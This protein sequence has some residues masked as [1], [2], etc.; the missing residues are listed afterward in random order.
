MTEPRTPGLHL[1][2]ER[3]VMLAFAAS[4]VVAAVV[5]T[6]FVYVR[7]RHTALEDAFTEQEAFARTL[8]AVFDRELESA[9]RSLE[10]LARQDAV[11]RVP[12]PARIS[13]EFNGVPESLE[14]DRRRVFQDFQ[15]KHPE[16]SVIFL[17]LP[18]GDQYISH[19]FAVQRRLVK[20]NLFDRPYFQEVAETRR[21][22]ISDS[23]LGSDGERAVA[24]D[25]P[26]LD[27]LGGIVAHLGGVLHLPDLSRFL[28]P[29]RIGPY[30]AGF[31]VDR[32]GALIAHTR[33]EMLTPVGLSQFADH[34]LLA[35]QPIPP[36]G[37]PG[38]KVVHTILYVDPV[39]GMEYS[40]TVLPLSD[41]RCFG[42]MRLMAEINGTVIGHSVRTAA[43][44]ALLMLIVS[45]VGMLA[46]HQV[47]QRWDSA[48]RALRRAHDEMEDQVRQRNADLLASY[49]ALERQ[50]AERK[51]A[52]EELRA[53][54]ERL[55][56]LVAA[57]TAQW[58][59]ANAKLKEEVTERQRAEES[60]SRRE[61]HLRAVV[62][63]APVILFATDR[64]GIF[65]VSEG[66]GLAGL[67][68][69]P[70]QV[71]GIS[72]FDV[73]LDRPDIH[74][75]IRRA[76]GG[77]RLTVDVRAGAAMFETA[78]APLVAESGETVGMIGVATDVSE[79]LRAEQ[80]LRRSEASQAKA[81]QIAHLGSWEWDLRTNEMTWSDELYRILG[82]EPGEAPASYEGYLE[83][84]HPAHREQ[85]KQALSRAVEEGG[86]V[87]LEHS[88]IQR[89]E[90]ERTV[91]LRAEV[92]AGVRATPM[93]V[94]A[95]VHD[96]HDRKLAEQELKSVAHQLSH[97]TT[98][99]LELAYLASHDLQEPANSILALSERIGERAALDAE[100]RTNLEL[101]HRAAAR[102][103]TL[104]QAMLSLAR[105]TTQAQPLVAIDLGGI[106]TEV[107]DDL[108]ARMEAS[109]GEVVVGNLPLVRGDPVQV[110]QLLQNLIG[111]ALKF[112]RPEESPRVRV[113]LAEALGEP[114]APPGF[115]QIAVEDNGIGFDPA[116]GGRLFQP[117]Q[118]LH[119]MGGYEGS[120]IGLAICKRI[121]ERHGGTITA[122][123][124]PN[125][126][127]RFV[128][129]LP[130]P[131]AD[132]S[133]AV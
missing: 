106:V 48:E 55:E 97:S 122:R 124:R 30:T 86:Q 127:A 115:C 25:V 93:H 6:A 133:P 59:A 81:Q 37:A 94:F 66:R 69:K 61:A 54:R 47:G 11:R 14:Q 65:T 131:Q 45:G 16:F 70:G 8:G 83:R 87:N 43:L 105:A 126:G 40:G 76:L 18:N 20:N 13:R 117:F 71:V 32:N 1:S 118:R 111:N 107:L 4:I 125:G 101:I 67:G 9:R 120:G 50:I 102:M 113:E 72:V 28:S 110:R 80:A 15:E 75:Y 10:F 33:P 82:M 62:N 132:A 98:N 60:L 104:I 73:Y 35:P 51:A 7:L 89:P 36:P 34:P 78:Y 41:G 88:L 22:V 103:T 68:L 128:F 130:L 53:H 52:E 109:G 116:L 19:P 84:V 64:N 112:H 121:V 85:V 90:T 23:F 26:I 56:E 39:D 21:P 108:S 74:A 58:E 99:L 44:V 63:S 77:E 49:A 31:V 129:T 2:F 57:R 114:P 46:A 27:A 92:N 91:H 96:V 100:S 5:V 95:T 24:I 123:T 3:K 119:E 42:L 17:A 29:S 38:Q 79:R 12:V